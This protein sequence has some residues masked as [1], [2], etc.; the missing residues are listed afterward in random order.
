MWIWGCS[1]W[2]NADV[3]TDARLDFIHIW[4][5]CQCLATTPT[6]NAENCTVASAAIMGHMKQSSRKDRPMPVI[7]TYKHTQ[8]QFVT[9]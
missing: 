7:Y 4:D 8:N 5:S 2:Q 1:M 6:P 3:S 9:R